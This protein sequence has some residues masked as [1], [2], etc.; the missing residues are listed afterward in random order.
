[1]LDGISGAF[2]ALRDASPRIFTAIAIASGALIFL[3]TPAIDAMGLSSVVESYRGYI[4]LS[5][6]ASI[7]FLL[8]DL[9]I[10]IGKQLKAHRQT[11]KSKANRVKLIES[12]TAE[13]RQYLAPYIVNGENT[14]YYAMDDGV[15]GVTCPH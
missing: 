14:C 9:V 7:V 1:M 10:W 11:K 2:Q 12:L 4:G 6:L 15:A 8:T 13:E 5:F 3:P